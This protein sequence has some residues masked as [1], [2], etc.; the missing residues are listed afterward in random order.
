MPRV[1]TTASCAGNVAGSYPK[2]MKGKE[3]GS[4]Y[5]LTA[6]KT[7]TIVHLGATPWRGRNARRAGTPSKHK[8]GYYSTRLDESNMNPFSGEVKIAIAS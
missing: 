2:L 4:V 5:L 7:G 6:P 8:I 3:S 1:V